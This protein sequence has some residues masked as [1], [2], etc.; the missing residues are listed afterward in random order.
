VTP[1]LRGNN[2]N[3]SNSVNDIPPNTTYSKFSASL[4]ASHA[5]AVFQAVVIVEKLIGNYQE[6]M[7]LLERSEEFLTS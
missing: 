2:I 4:A 6:M 1:N 5:Q 3:N 7:L